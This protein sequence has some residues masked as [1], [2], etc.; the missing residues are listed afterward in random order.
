MSHSGLEL[1]NFYTVMCIIALATNA[2]QLTP[3]KPIDLQIIKLENSLGINLIAIMQWLCEYPIFKLILSIIYDSL[4]YQ[5]SILPLCVI[6]SGQFTVLNE[7]FMLMLITALIGFMIY[8]FFPTTAPAS[9]LDSSLFL[10]EQVDTGLKFFQIHHHQTPTTN[11][12]GLI[13][14]PSFHTVWAILCVYLI[15]NWR[16]PC[17]LL[18]LINLLLIMSCVLLGWHYPSD[19]IAGFALVLIAYYWLKWI[20]I[21]S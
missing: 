2:V 8:Y 7:Y 3:F 13:A 10:P 6:I 12:G 17:M 5:M 16:L 18:G 11:E 4:P 9:M 21:R 20:K 19:I 14:M 1:I 15:K